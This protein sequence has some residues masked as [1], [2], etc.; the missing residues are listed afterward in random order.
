M[1]TIQPKNRTIR[2]IVQA[3]KL[4]NSD[5]T[6]EEIDQYTSLVDDENLSSTFGQRNEDFETMVFMNYNICWSIEVNDPNGTDKN[7]RV[8]LNSVIHKPYPGNPQFFTEDPLKVDPATGK[9]CGTIAIDPNLPEKD[10]S[11][12]IEFDIEYV[13]NVGSTIVSVDLDPK[14][15]IRSGN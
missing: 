14:L 15:K 7:Y 4:F 12:T 6:P 1:S 10:D 5:I 2:L 8:A 13:D 9:V 3:N 11:Y